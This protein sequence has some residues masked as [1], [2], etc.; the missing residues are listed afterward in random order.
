MTQERRK[1]PRRKPP[2]EYALLV[3]TAEMEQ[4]AGQRHNLAIKLVDMCPKGALIVTAGRL[5]EGVHLN[6]EIHNT[7]TEAHFRGKGTIRWSQTW[8]HGGREANVAGL[9]F[10]EVTEVRG[11]EMEYFSSWSKVSSGAEALREHA[12]VTPP[13]CAASCFAGG[14]LGYSSKN[15]ARRLVDLSE[16]GAQLDLME[17]LDAG[18]KVRIR[19][20]FK[21]SSAD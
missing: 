17:K 14:M 18:K 12:R 10:T 7:R 9:E 20:Q 2:P 1:Y 13:D 5:R 8:T 15:I 3:S 16:G 19:L 4:R 6:V 21:S 11:L